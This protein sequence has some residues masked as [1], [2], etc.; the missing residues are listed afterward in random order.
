MGGPLDLKIG[1]RHQPSFTRSLPSGV[2]LYV[3]LD[4]PDERTNLTIIRLSVG[5]LPPKG[6]KWYRINQY[7]IKK[8]NSL[9]CYLKSRITRSMDHPI[10]AGRYEGTCEWTDNW[11]LFTFQAM[12]MKVQQE[13]PKII[14]PDSLLPKNKTRTLVLP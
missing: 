3:N 8:T 2:S 5:L 14:V 1:Y 11:C 10:P 4:Q 7:R 12:T 6:K 9:T 13:E